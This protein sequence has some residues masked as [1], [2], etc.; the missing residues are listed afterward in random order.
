[1][2]NP[3]Y[4]TGLWIWN[5]FIICRYEWP[6]FDAEIPKPARPIQS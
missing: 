5:L 2:K 4:P 6:E 1:M 3:V